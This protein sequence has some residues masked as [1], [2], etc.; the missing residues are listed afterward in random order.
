MFISCVQANVINTHILFNGGCLW[1]WWVSYKKV[2][3][4]LHHPCWI[5]SSNEDDLL[6]Q[7]LETRNEELPSWFSS[8]SP[9]WLLVLP[10]RA[11]K[12]AVY[13]GAKTRCVWKHSFTYLWDIESFYSRKFLGFKSQIWQYW[14]ERVV[15]TTTEHRIF[16][17]HAFLFQPNGSFQFVLFF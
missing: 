14:Y 5:S 12:E 16:T 3:T 6:A 8:Y 1:K 2:G 7:Q 10:R 4:S 13:S 17:S 11:C 15:S 9:T